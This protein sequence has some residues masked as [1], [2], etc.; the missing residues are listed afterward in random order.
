MTARMRILYLAV[1]AVFFWMFLYVDSWLA[2]YGLLIVLV[3]PVLS[4]LVSLPAMLGCR[5]RVE[6]CK[7][8]CCRGEEN[9][10]RITVYNTARLPLPRVKVRLTMHQTLTGVTL[11]KT[12]RYH[13]LPATLNDR[14]PMDT[15][16][17]G[18]WEAG[19]HWVQVYDALG[20]I[21]IRRRVLVTAQAA[22]L[23]QPVEPETLP[24][25]TQ[26]QEQTT[27]QRPRR[28]DGMG[29][30]YELRTYQPGD[31]V[32]MIH[33]KLSSKSEELILREVLEHPEAVPVLT[34]DHLGPPDL[35]DG[36]LDR[37]W[38]LSNT[39]LEQ[40]KAH[41]IQ[42]VHPESGQQF[43][44]LLRGQGDLHRCFG[45]LLSQPAPLEGHRFPTGLRQAADRY[46]Y[47]LEPVR[48]EEP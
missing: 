28:G 2:A 36:V 10:W 24:Q 37:L 3:M 29:E 45:A 47:H 35:L 20:L 8:Q 26:S 19:V 31:P 46:E 38:S 6:G 27:A 18:I 9:Q 21:A 13:R 32:R 48:E 41:E 12:M 25:T 5:V 33:W 22:V 11:T 15:N 17:C 42:W 23:P 16:H 44:F 14:L 34:F 4:L 1:L 7:G 40:Q 30:E 39:L 43:R